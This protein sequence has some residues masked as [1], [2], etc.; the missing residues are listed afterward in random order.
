MKLR[1][2]LLRKVQELITKAI[3]Y[4]AVLVG[5]EIRML[6]QDIQCLKENHDWQNWSATMAGNVEQMDRDP[7]KRYSYRACNH[8]RLEM[9]DSRS[10]YETKVKEKNALEFYDL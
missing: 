10:Y 3:G 7:L 2:W 9:P 6:K 1:M 8:C 4:D 5:S